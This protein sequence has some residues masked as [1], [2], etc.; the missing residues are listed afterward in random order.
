[1]RSAQLG[2]FD[3]NFATPGSAR[4][5]ATV[6]GHEQDENEHWTM[7]VRLDG[8]RLIG[9][10]RV[11]NRHD[12]AESGARGRLPAVGVYGVVSWPGYPRSTRVAVWDGSLDGYFHGLDSESAEDDLAV[13]PSGAAERTGQDGSRTR[14]F[15]GGDLLHIGPAG[16]E[17]RPFRVRAR[18]YLQTRAKHTLDELDEAAER[19]G[20]LEV[21]LQGWRQVRRLRA[22][23]WRDRGELTVDAESGRAALR[24]ERWPGETEQWRARFEGEAGASVAALT[25]RVG[26]GA[27]GLRASLF[28]ASAR[29]RLS[30][31]SPA[32][33]AELD[34]DGDR[35]RLDAE[36]TSVGRPALALA[37]LASAPAVDEN[38][39]TLA[40]EIRR[41]RDRLDRN[42]LR[43][44]LAPTLYAPFAALLKIP[45]PF[46]PRIPLRPVASPN[47]EAQEA[48]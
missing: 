21:L 1:M 24:A 32:T 2:G 42:D 33:H 20:P 28:E 11:L 13:H 22:R 40:A 46:G 6:I 27:S 7:R 44:Q 37:P 16:V 19:G 23:L 48:P 17:P 26:A 3:G 34:L 4:A 14:R 43:W 36:M 10:V 25:E 38:L 15:V 31:T 5:F 29:A 47:I 18:D 12:G 9:G 45:L 8:G 39:E 41:L 30:A 35:A